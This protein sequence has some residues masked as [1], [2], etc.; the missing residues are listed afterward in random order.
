MGATQEGR[1]QV[2][3]RDYGSGSLRQRPDGFWEGRLDLGRDAHGHRRRPSFTGRT[4]RE[5]QQ[6]IAAALHRR[7][8]GMAVGSP[9][10]MT[11]AAFLQAWLQDAARPAVRA[12]TFRGYETI[13]RFHLVPAI[14]AVPLSKLGAA[15]VQE[16]LNSKIAGGLSPQSV[17]NIHA[18]LRRALGQAVRWDMLPRNVASLV[19]LPRAERFEAHALGADEARAILEAMRGDRL[20]GLVTVTLAIGLR[21]GEALGLR[22]PDVDLEGD[23]LTV[24]HALQRIDGHLQLTEP[25]TARSRRTVALPAFAVTA[26]REHRRRQLEDRLL[27]GSRWHEGGYVFASSIG[28]PLDGVGVTHRFQA[29]LVAAG[30]PR[31]RFHDLRHGAASLLMAQGVHPRVVMETLGHSTIAMTMNLYSHVV[32][33][34]QRD[35]ADRMEALLGG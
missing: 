10:R 20:E 28:T 6:A 2:T 30:L 4:K 32:P 11:V 7:E 24:R 1:L 9:D 27:A 35:A 14:G 15:H 21:Q 16:L 19:D 26:L 8:A 31:L 17:R 29:R 22:W 5:V 23:T 3:R 34:L 18:V 12:R 25:K 33:A 13:V